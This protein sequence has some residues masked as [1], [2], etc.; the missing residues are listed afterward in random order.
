[1]AAKEKTVEDILGNPVHL[2][3]SDNALRIRRNLL[4]VSSIALFIAWSGLSLS[5]DSSILGMKF[6]GLSDQAVKQAL[7][8]VI[9]YFFIHY[10]WYAFDSM[11]EWRLRITGMKESFFGTF[12]EDHA[13]YPREIRQSSL[14]NWWTKVNCNMELMEPEIARISEITKPMLT[15]LQSKA[16]KNK[17]DGM[18]LEPAISELMAQITTLVNLNS[19]NQQYMKRVVT[20]FENP[21]I[22]TSLSRF[23]KWFYLFL[24]SQNLR[25]LINDIIL[26]I[27][28]AIIAII[29]LIQTNDSILDFSQLVAT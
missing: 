28:I 6:V 10:V 1:M 8:L 14:Y 15:A 24:Q 7:T 26:P 20:V 19:S 18:V 5:P 9:L 2:D 22:T 27:G 13:D 11:I 4:A 29:F 3:M 17:S 21:R 23:D 25:F 16:N 12:G